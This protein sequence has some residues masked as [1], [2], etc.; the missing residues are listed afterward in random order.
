M[1]KEIFVVIRGIEKF[2]IFLVPKPFLIRID[3]KGILGFME[4]KIK[5]ASTRATPVLAIMA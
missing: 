1:E 4:K 2:S 5:Y 3:S